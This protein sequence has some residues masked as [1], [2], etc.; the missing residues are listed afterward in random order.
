MCRGREPA[1]R[2]RKAHRGAL[3]DLWAPHGRY[4][5]LVVSIARD[6]H[7]RWGPGP[8]RAQMRDLQTSAP[9]R[10]QC[11]QRVSAAKARRHPDSS[12]VT[13]PCATGPTGHSGGGLSPSGLQ[14]SSDQRTARLAITPRANVHFSRGVNLS[15]RLSASET[16]TGQ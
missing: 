13:L 14:F 8:A 7:L 2:L 15:T 3:Q 1:Y 5:D 11:V 12:W 10:T 4:S 9:H 6:P 16:E